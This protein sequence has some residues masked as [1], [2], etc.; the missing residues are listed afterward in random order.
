[1]TTQWK[2]TI[3]YTKAVNEYT[4]DVCCLLYRLVIKRNTRNPSLGAKQLKCTAEN[5]PPSSVRYRVCSSTSSSPM[6]LHDL[7]LGTGATFFSSLTFTSLP[8]LTTCTI[9][10]LMKSISVREMKRKDR[11]LKTNC[12]RNTSVTC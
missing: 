5:L 9:L 6:C 8:A 7:V 2:C 1:M 3:C 11:I 10:P 12:V 4:M